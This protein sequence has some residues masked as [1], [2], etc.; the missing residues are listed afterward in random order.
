MDSFR[1][2]PFSF[3]G[4]GIDQPGLKTSRPQG[5]ACMARPPA[6]LNRWRRNG[7]SPQSCGKPAPSPPP[8]RPAVTRGWRP[9]TRAESSWRRTTCRMRRIALPPG[10]S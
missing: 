4:P 2:C 7:H 10:Y 3:R 5:A 1:A 9:G 8:Q 6:S